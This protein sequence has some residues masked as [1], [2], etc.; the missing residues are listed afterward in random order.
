[1]GARPDTLDMVRAIAE[2]AYRAGARFVDVPWFDPWVKRTRLLHADPDT[3]DWVPPWYGERMMR[4]GALSAANIALASPITPGLMDDVDPARAARDRLPATREGTDVV[5]S[6]RLNWTVVPC[7]TPA[8]AA[9]V[10]PDLPPD[11]AL[12]RLWADIAHVCR[13]DDDDPAASWRTRG[14]E[15]RAAAARLTGLG[16]DRLR[17]RGPG[18]DLTVG[19]LPTSRW[20]G[21]GDQTV[22]GLRHMPNL[23]TE[24]VFTTPDPARTEGVVA[25]TKPLDVAGTIIRGLRVRF[26]GGRAVEIAA[27]HGAEVL[28]GRVAADEGGARLGEV[29]LVDGS[30]RIGALDTVFYDTLLDENAASHIALG[31]GYPNGAGPEDRERVNA[32][33]IHVDFMIGGPEVTVTGVTRDGTEVTV[34]AGGGGV[35]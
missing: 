34:L 16:L 7:P 28:R 14:E 9:L 26:E 10:H 15:L 18:T 6:G 27:D 23:P 22:D 31:A 8:W 2:V 29:A 24:E 5:M 3:L 17:F 1:M 21:G 25:S 11:A 33:Q 32:S 20:V 13:L 35:V 30:G 12:A 4:L 19:L